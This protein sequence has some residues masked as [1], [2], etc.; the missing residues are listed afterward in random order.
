MFLLRFLLSPGESA[1]VK[2]EQ[3]TSVVSMAEISTKLGSHKRQRHSHHIKRK[4]AGNL[5]HAVRIAEAIGT[6]LKVFVTINFALT[7]GCAGS[8]ASDRFEDLRSNYFGPWIRRPPRK[9]GRERDP[10]AYVWVLEN[11]SKCINL[12]WLVHIPRDRIAEFKRR[13]PKWLTSVGITILDEGALRIEPARK[14]VVLGFYLLKGIDPPYAGFYGVKF[15]SP[16]GM[17]FGKRSGFSR[18]LGP[19]AKG[20][21]RAEGRYRPRRFVKWPAT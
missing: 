15:H 19:T 7:S 6:P 17:I 14:P 13:M 16:Q 3:R 18:S 5:Y 2:S 21:L 9:L 20:R 1:G 10:C 11:S 12:H 4:P 8:E